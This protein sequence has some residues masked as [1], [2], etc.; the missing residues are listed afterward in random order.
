[1]ENVVT[2]RV[3]A[4][5]VVG[6]SARIAW[7]KSPL[8]GR[9]AAVQR[10]VLIGFT[11]GSRTLVHSVRAP[12]S[13]GNA[14]EVEYA[15]VLDGHTLNLRA[16]LPASARLSE[17]AELLLES[18]GV[19]LTAGAAL[20]TGEGGAPELTAAVL[21]G[22]ALGGVP[23]DQGRWRLSVALTGPDGTTARLPLLGPGRPV[24]VA[25]PAGRYPVCPRTGIRYRTGLTST[26]QLQINVSA[27]APAVEVVRVRTGLS[28]LTVDFTGLAGLPEP[29]QVQFTHGRERLLRPAAPVPGH[30]HL[31]RVEVPL[32]EIV[33]KGG[34][35]VWELS[36]A[37]GGKG[38]RSSFRRRTHDLRTPGRVLTP[39]RVS[40]LAP[41]GRIF[42]VQARY[43]RGGV[44]RLTCAPAPGLV[45]PNP[46]PTGRLS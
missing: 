7:N 34:S 18:G 4:L 39:A 41:N 26:G 8:A 20:R 25:G 31:L 46:S 13:M 15:A 10:R 12:L 11:E 21:L 24:A 28:R 2:R 22:A 45:A 9:R 42:Y 40:A 3:H 16:V 35:R 1:M 32:R 43:A 33:A 27:P 29:V 30:E 38:S 17:H 37:D 36:L 19:R 5:K 14:V 23:L 44:L 6:R